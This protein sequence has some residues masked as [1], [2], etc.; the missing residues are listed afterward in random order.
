MVLHMAEIVQPLIGNE[1]REVVASRIKIV[2]DF[3]FDA[4]FVPKTWGECRTRIN[5]S[6]DPAL[7]FLDYS[8]PEDFR[9]AFNAFNETLSAQP[10]VWFANGKLDSVL[11]AYS[12]LEELTETFGL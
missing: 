1:D 8:D 11:S 6:I 12:N 7:G 10:F 3:W 9:T 2:S 4:P 5:E